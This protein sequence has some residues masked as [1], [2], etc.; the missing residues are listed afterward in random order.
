[1]F[2]WWFSDPQSNLSTVSSHQT[3]VCT[4][5]ILGEQEDPSKRDASAGRITGQV[6]TAG[7]GMAS[8]M[9]RSWYQVSKV[10][11]LHSIGV[12][13]VLVELY[14]GYNGLP[15]NA[16]NKSGKIYIFSSQMKLFI[17]IATSK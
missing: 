12:L 16:Q 17:N 8:Y 9:Y 13:Y 4:M 1:M 14:I 7:A 3:W 5:Y 10:E 2:Y 15:G 11:L 6:F